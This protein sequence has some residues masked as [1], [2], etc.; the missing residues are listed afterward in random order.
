MRF[1]ALPLL[2]SSLFAMGACSSSPTIVPEDRPA[3]VTLKDM[4]TGLDLF[5]ANEA[6]T[7]RSDYYSQARRTADLK[8]VPNL[9][10]GALMMAL[11]DYGFFTHAQVG[12]RRTPGART[13]LMVEVG[14]E[15]YTMSMSPEQP[16]SEIERA[17]NCNSAFR[18]LFNASFSMQLIDNPEGRALFEDQQRE[19][20]EDIRRRG[21][22]PKGN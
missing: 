17:I 21:S 13:T 19:F 16:A 4:R 5:L 3:L 6:H 15:K 14:D 2:I 8:V 9:D 1:L 22:N 11:E 7:N 10:M 12:L 20:A 18:A